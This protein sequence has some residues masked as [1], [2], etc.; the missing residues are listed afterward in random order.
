[1]TKVAVVGHVE[2]IEFARV[3]EVPRPGQIVHASGTFTA[4]AGGGPVAAVQLL[5]LAGEATLFT[6]LGDDELGHRAAGELRAMGLRVEAVFRPEA[7]RRG[8]VYLDDR[9]ERTITVIGERLGP[10]GSDRLPWEELAS[11]DGVYFTAGDHAALA[12]AREARTLVAT[13]RAM[14]VLRDSGV[15]LDALVGSARDPAERPEA[16]D[17]S[18]KA[19]V[20]T[21]GPKGGSWTTADGRSGAWD[22]AP[23]PGPVR[24]AYGC[25]D[26]FAGGLTFALAR[27]DTIEEAVALGARCG[28]ACLTGRGP[29]EGQLRAADGA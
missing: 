27:G 16:L 6:A 7:Q 24:D 17:P 12:R 9:G 1:M 4:P 13:A 21:A 5:R 28:A 3:A 25:G 20:M 29:Y 8:F 10:A 14:P 15:R 18:P 22:A 19:V 26:S 23:L 2:W 11:Y